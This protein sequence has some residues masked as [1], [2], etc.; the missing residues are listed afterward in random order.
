MEWGEGAPPSSLSMLPEAHSLT[1]LLL[2]CCCRRPR[3]CCLCRSGFC[4]GDLYAHNVLADEAGNAVLCDYG[5]AG[6]RRL[7]AGGGRR[8]AGGSRGAL[9]R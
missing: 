5:E 9:Q 2:L 4:H 7:A 6:G 1:C 8:A 3:H